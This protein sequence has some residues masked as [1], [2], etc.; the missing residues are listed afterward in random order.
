MVEQRDRSGQ[1]VSS[2]E[3]RVVEENYLQHLDP[4]ARG[5][6]TALLK[7]Q[8]SYGDSWRRRG[9]VGAYMMLAR[10]SD[11]IEIQVGRHN[12]DIFAA[13][14]ADTRS[15]GIIDDIRDLRRYLLL[16]EAELVARGSMSALSKHRDDP[17][18]IG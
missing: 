6:V 5:D 13:A 15:E 17:A 2:R 14:E 9:G 8:E 11:R 4:I 18:D 10:K 12:Y 3:T 16:V 1:D 7:A